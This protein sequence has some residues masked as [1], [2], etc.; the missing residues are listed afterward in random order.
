M[1]KEAL[2]DI[3][4]ND[5]KEVHALV[6]TF[7]G[8]QELNVAF[9]N[10][11]RTKIANI[12]EELSLLEQLN[13]KKVSTDTNESSLTSTVPAPSVENDNSAIAESSSRFVEGESNMVKEDVVNH[14]HAPQS[15]AKAPVVD[16][17][18]PAGITREI[19]ERPKQP[20]NKAL[21]ATV[22]TIHSRTETMSGESDTRH[23]DTGSTEAAND[24][25]HISNDSVVVD[26]NTKP[27]DSDSLSNSS[28]TNQSGNE[29][30]AAVTKTVQA[31][32]ESPQ[33]KSDASNA[34]IE[35]R[36]I[37]HN[38]V[39]K[40]E[41]RKSVLGEVINQESSSV[42]D[43]LANKKEIVE[44]IKQIGKPVDD[45]KKAFGLNDRFYY[46][47]ELFNNNADLFNQ[48]LDQINSM[49]SY[50]SAI[51]FLQSNYSWG[52]NNEASEAFFKS[53]KRRFI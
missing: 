44:D 23:S 27:S 12:N 20:D 36:T 41:A 19:E 37:S 31:P 47:R 34:G 45:V 18:G 6:N 48:T 49:E 2:I 1:E 7:K 4:L 8:K 5:I 24:S 43:I 25:S 21:S 26:N 53:I 14:T 30:P 13:V 46:Q 29:T 38:A 35:K 33:L 22:D 39:P 52:S 42:N 32:K 28:H 40:K 15:K 3:I 17:T 16:P 9:I 51:S 50:D 11:T 10:L